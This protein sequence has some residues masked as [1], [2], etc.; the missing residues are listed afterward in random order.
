[1]LGVYAAHLTIVEA[2]RVLANQPLRL[3]WHEDAIDP[4]RCKIGIFFDRHGLHDTDFGQAHKQFHRS[5]AFDED[6][7]Q[8]WRAAAEDLRRHLLTV[9][10]RDSDGSTDPLPDDAS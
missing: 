5:L 4:H 2:C 10:R 6:S 7:G 3:R 1:M 8:A 9:L